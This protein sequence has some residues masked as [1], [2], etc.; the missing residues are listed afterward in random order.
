MLIRKNVIIS[1][2]WAGELQEQHGVGARHGADQ[3]R[4]PFPAL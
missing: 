4:Q 3:Q 1:P 2:S